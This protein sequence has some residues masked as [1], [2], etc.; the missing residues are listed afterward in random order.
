M[1]H[2][3]DKHLSQW[4]VRPLHLRHA[5]RHVHA[6]PRSSHGFVDTGRPTRSFRPPPARNLS[7]RR[8][9][10]VLLPR[11]VHP[12]PHSL[13]R[14]SHLHRSM[15]I[16]SPLHPL[17][18]PECQLA[19][20]TRSLLLPG[21]QRVEHR[22]NRPLLS[23]SIKHTSQPPNHRCPRSQTRHRRASQRTHSSIETGSKPS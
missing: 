4:L 13:C 11:V 1:W 8:R 6:A 16:A 12:I 7:S 10:V 15:G 23:P 17:P 20:N 3:P 2:T 14:T 9:L 22:S 19:F 21:S 5:G 18:C